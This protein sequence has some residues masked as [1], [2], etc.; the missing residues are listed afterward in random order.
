MRGA[1]E[2]PGGQ[3][4][5][6][7]W[8]QKGKHRGARQT[9]S[10][11]LL[12]PDLRTP[13]NHRKSAPFLVK[14]PGLT[15]PPPIRTH[16][17]WPRCISPER[18]KTGDASFHSLYSGD[19]VPDGGLQIPL[20]WGYTRPPPGCPT[21]QCALRADG[22]PWGCHCPPGVLWLQ[23]LPHPSDGSPND[24]HRRHVSR[25]ADQIPF[26]LWT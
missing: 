6:G 21:V 12:C 17:V 3:W 4:G 23:L 2:E 18:E 10:M 22:C 5:T 11:V 25:S 20:E 16:W 19:K 8:A 1:S 14:A 26:Q 15:H 24:G 7:C 13:E 9:C